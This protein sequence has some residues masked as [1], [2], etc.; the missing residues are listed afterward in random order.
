M[1]KY[2]N[3]VHGEE[4]QSKRDRKRLTIQAKLTKLNETFYL[5]RDH[6]YRTL[7]QSAQEELHL[8]TGKVSSTEATGDQSYTDFEEERDLELVRLALFEKYEIDRAEKDF[9]EEVEMANKEHDE[10]V[11]LVKERLYASL[12]RQVKQLKE[13]KVLLDV[14]N[15]HSYSM[16]MEPLSGTHEFQ[17]HTR[18]QQKE[19]EKDQ[20]PLAA[21]GYLSDRRGLRRRGGLLGVGGGVTTGGESGNEDSHVSANESG[22]NSSAKRSRL[23]HS[24]GNGG[25]NSSADESWLSDTADLSSLLF[26]DRKPDKP[27]TRHSS[28]SYNPPQGLKNDEVNEDLAMLRSLR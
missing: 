26:G 22:N 9:Y 23:A 7:L 8:I 11:K 1:E 18:S 4:T 25:K 2:Q 27:A 14:A 16:A 28:K 3:G 21:I 12:E 19:K 13:D 20:Q 6:H 15:S 10:M 24:H 17:K 5:E